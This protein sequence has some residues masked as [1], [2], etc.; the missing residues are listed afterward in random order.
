MISRFVGLL[1]GALAC[2]LV[3]ACSTSQPAAPSNTGPEELNYSPTN[4]NHR[5]R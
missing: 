5:R 1:G 4:A 3:A 2:A